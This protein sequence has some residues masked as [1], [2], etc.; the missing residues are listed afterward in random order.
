MQAQRSWAEAQR[1]TAA[2]RRDRGF[3]QQGSC[4]DIKC[5]ICN[6]NHFARNCPDRMHPSV[7]AKGKGK[8]NYAAV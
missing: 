8:F 7:K 5:Y 2:L 3:G 1:A 4:S 6:G